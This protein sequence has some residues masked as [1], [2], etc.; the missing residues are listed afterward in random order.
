M[1]NIGN[2][3]IIFVFPKLKFIFLSKEVEILSDNIHIKKGRCS[4]N[5]DA[6]KWPTYKFPIWRI[7]DH[8]WKQLI[9]VVN[10]LFAL[11]VNEIPNKTFLLDSH[12]PFL[13]SVVVTSMLQGTNQCWGSEIWVNPS[14]LPPLSAWVQL[15]GNPTGQWDWAVTLCM[16]ETLN[17][18]Y[19]SWHRYSFKSASLKK[20][21]SQLIGNYL[22][23]TSLCWVWVD[24]FPILAWPH[25][26][27]N[28]NLRLSSY[29]YNFLYDTSLFFQY[30]SLT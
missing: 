19:V 22:K 15:T 4:S 17:K 26:L 20:N 13:C 11:R 6:H 1:R 2:V 25:Q 24:T 27:I 21:Q 5:L 30:S 23:S 3:S 12:R 8:K 18:P 10:F 14:P 7:V 28:W 16:G 9:L 29:E